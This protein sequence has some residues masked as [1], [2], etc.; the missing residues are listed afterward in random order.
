MYYANIERNKFYLPGR[1]RI[2]INDLKENK[3]YAE[4]I[5]TY[6]SNKKYI[7]KVCANPYTGNVLVIFSEKNITVE[8]VEKYIHNAKKE[9]I[10]Q[11]KDQMYS[12]REKH[13]DKNKWIFSEK[14]VVGVMGKKSY[15]DF[16]LATIGFTC[17]VLKKNILGLFV[18]AMAYVNKMIEDYMNKQANKEVK[19]ILRNRPGKVYKLY[20]DH[21]VKI[22]YKDIHV[23]E[24]IF[25][26]EGELVPI[27]GK[28]IK[29]Q[30]E[31]INPLNAD[32]KTAI[33]VNEGDQIWSGSII[34]KGE[35]LVN[36][37]KVDDT[38]EYRKL[39][40]VINEDH[41]RFE[42]TDL[43]KKYD[44]QMIF[45][46][47]FFMM[48][49]CIVIGDLWRALTI[50]FL[51]YPKPGR[52]AKCAAL[53]T[54]VT[55]A[56]V[57][58]IF[59]KNPHK[60]KILSQ[61]NK[62]V[63]DQ[64]RILATEELRIGD[65]IKV[66]M[67]SENRILRIASSCEKTCMYPIRKAL[68][69]E[70]EKR[71]LKEKNIVHFDHPLN[72]SEYCNIEKKEVVVGNKDCMKENN[73]SIEKYAMKEKKLKHL[74]Q[75][76]IY[77]AYNHKIIGLIG[78]QDVVRKDALSSIECMREQ[79]IQIEIISSDSKETIENKAQELGIK[80]YMGNMSKE[81][82]IERIKELKEKG[83]TV[84]IVY[85]HIEDSSSINHAHVNMSFIDVCDYE[86]ENEFHIII[87]NENVLSIPSTI[88]LS[89]YT[90][91]K[92]Y[93]NE[94]FSI[95]FNTIGTLFALTNGIPLF[96]VSLYKQINNVIV[97]HN[98]M[99]LFNHKMKYLDR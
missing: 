41:E 26:N 8:Q 38:F 39:I 49:H 40:S 70:I 42:T 47:V 25:L 23:G 58:G 92:M 57:K 11:K 50:V 2:K 93:Q 76:S 75:N 36:V 64:T 80:N 87:L 85:E 91:E 17:I 94:I 72:K 52:V 13:S 33:S 96:F 74:G 7:D 9:E 99:G 90:M 84:G 12:M 55:K 61:L 62:M 54:V 67:N 21:R 14:H 3:K 32:I 86:E 19:S 5:N 66:D 53:K 29:G 20:N 15:E 65:V 24:T 35:L 95:G 56:Y 77:V 43:Q 73:I 46:I 98:T 10:H 44:D 78:I 51:L 88:D 79:G 68:N 45:Y 81:D 63:F 4:K 18:V 59:I 69:K 31:L 1:L 6:L 48:V 28:I 16:I 22:S 60:I 34:K 27:D 37:S 83:H 89:K 82:K 97:F 71:K 30:A